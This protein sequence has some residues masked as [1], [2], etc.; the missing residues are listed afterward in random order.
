MALW[1]MVILFGALWI[2]LVL[3]DPSGMARNPYATGPTDRIGEPLRSIL[4]GAGGAIVLVGI[5]GAVRDVFRG[6]RS[7]STPGTHPPPKD[8]SI[9]A[10]CGGILEDQHRFCPHCGE[11]RESMS[12]S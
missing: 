12:D 11:D 1:A 3:L 5:L 9:C 7:D 2:A 4:L 10:R 8:R 6:T